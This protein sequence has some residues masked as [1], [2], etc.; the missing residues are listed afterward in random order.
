MYLKIKM[1]GPVA[2]TH[3]AIFDIM[4]THFVWL[5]DKKK[6]CPIFMGILMTKITNLYKNV[7]FEVSCN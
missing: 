2:I 6:L 7:L 3:E 1:S 4:L 5:L